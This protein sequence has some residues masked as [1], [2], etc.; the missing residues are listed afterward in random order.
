MSDAGTS[1]PDLFPSAA[2]PFDP[3]AEIALLNARKASTLDDLAE[4]KAQTPP[5]HAIIFAAEASLRA[6][7]TE[8]QRLAAWPNY[9]ARSMQPEREDGE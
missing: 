6:I 3:M 5:N 4:A 7:H 8:T 9:L 2:L 1:T